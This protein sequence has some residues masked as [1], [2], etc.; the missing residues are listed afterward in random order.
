MHLVHL[1]LPLHDNHGHQFS[2][3]T[4]G[5]VREEL[6]ERFGGVTAF[7]RSPALGLWKDD[8]AET[9]SDDVVMF[10][11]MCEE[12]DRSWWTDYRHQLERLFKQDEVLIWATEATKL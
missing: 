11:V 5:S 6:T 8:S 9:T 7:I 4:F 2:Q 12:L 10:E 1:L 3:E